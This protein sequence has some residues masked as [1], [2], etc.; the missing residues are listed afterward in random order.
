MDVGM[1][2]HVNTGEDHG[3]Q[4]V[5][6]A[7][8]ARGDGAHRRGTLGAAQEVLVVEQARESVGLTVGGPALV[9]QQLLQRG[10]VGLAEQSRA[11]RRMQRRLQPCARGAATVCEGVCN[12]VRRGLQPRATGAAT[13][14]D[15]G[16]NRV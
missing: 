7:P 5:P 6:R 4:E 16:C 9:R 10:H 12:R 3:T 11:R 8:G 1:D 13:V 2:A 15:G 14:C